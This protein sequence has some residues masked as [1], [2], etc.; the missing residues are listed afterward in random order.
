MSYYASF[1][2]WLYANPGG[3]GKGAARNWNGGTSPKNI[4][5]NMIAVS[6]PELTDAISKLKHVETVK[7]TTFD[8]MNYM[9]AEM[10]LTFKRKKLGA[11]S[12][13]EQYELIK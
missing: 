3:I 11:Y 9:I 12:D 2:S 6:Q 5:A 8:P 10:H 1:L 4:Q 13:Y 7:K